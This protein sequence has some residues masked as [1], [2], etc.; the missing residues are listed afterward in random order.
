MIRYFLIANKENKPI[1]NFIRMFAY[2]LDS[3]HY[4][5]E[6]YIEYQQIVRYDIVVD[7][8]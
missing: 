4:P 2:S 1:L 3:I 6:I 5:V 8:L 7:R